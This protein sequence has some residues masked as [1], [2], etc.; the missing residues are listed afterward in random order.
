MCAP[1]CIRS[2]GP[3]PVGG[4]RPYSGGCGGTTTSGECLE[5]TQRN[6]F[7]SSPASP[8]KTRCRHNRQ[9][10][11]TLSPP[12][13]Q[14]GPA[15]GGSSPCSC[16]AAAPPLPADTDRTP[17][18]AAADNHHPRDPSEQHDPA[19]MPQMKTR[20]L[21]ELAKTAL[22]G[23]SSIQGLA[24]LMV[25]HDPHGADLVPVLWPLPPGVPPVLRRR[26]RALPTWS[27]SRDRQPLLRSDG[28]DPGLRI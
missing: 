16:P 19:P 3:S 12:Y 25:R 9:N 26:R 6:H 20:H 24:P 10:N 8:L 5:E 15:P 28:N 2:C 23:R 27:Q 1:T 7:S 14:S 17:A 21:S 22:H 13:I 4:Y 11:I 18:A